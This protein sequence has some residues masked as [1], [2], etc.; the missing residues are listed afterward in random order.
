MQGGGLT[1]QAHPVELTGGL[2]MGAGGGGRGQ[3]RIHHNSQGRFH[4]LILPW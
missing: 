1:S 3:G 4:A 2:G